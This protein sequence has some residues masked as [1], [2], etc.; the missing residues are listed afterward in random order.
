MSL[1][2]SSAMAEVSA[3]D[4]AGEGPGVMAPIV[5]Q[6]TSGGSVM[7]PGDAF[8]IGA[9]FSRAAGDLVLS[10]AADQPVVVVRDFFAMEEPPRLET[11]SGARIEGALA[12]RLAGSPSPGQYAA[13]D[14]AA[15][16]SSEPIGKI[17]EITGEAT[18]TRLDGTKLAL[19]KDMPIF[20]GDVI[21]TAEGAAAKVVFIDESTFAIGENG[22]IVLDELVFDPA[23]L[24]G[25]SSFSVLEGVFIFVSGGIAENNPD[26]MVVKT[27]VATMG[28]RGTAVA[29]QAAEESEQNLIILL[30]EQTEDGQE[31]TGAVKVTTDGGSVVLDEPNEATSLDSIFALPSDTFYALPEDIAFLIR[32]LQEAIPDSLRYLKSEFPGD[33]QAGKGGPEE[34]AAALGGI[35]PAAGETG[36]APDEVIQVTNAD[37][38]ATSPFGVVPP[39][40]LSLIGFE[41]GGGGAG[42]SEHDDVLPLP[43]VPGAIVGE[44]EAPPPPPAPPA[45]DFILP[46]GLFKLAQ[47]VDPNDILVGTLHTSGP[48]GASFTF[49][50]AGTYLVAW[51]AMDEGDF[52]I[53]S[54]LLLDSVFLNDTLLDGFNG[55]TFSFAG[56][57]IPA[58]ADVTFAGV[59][60]GVAPVE[61]AGQLKFDNNNLSAAQIEALLGLPP[62]SLT[63]LAN[64]GNP[65]TVDVAT[66]GSVLLL[67]LTVQAGDVL[68][69]GYNF[70][71]TDINGG[72][73]GNF[74]DFAFFFVDA[75]AAEGSNIA[76][77]GDDVLVGG[78]G[79]DVI[80]ALAGNDTVFGSSGADSLIG[81]AGDDTLFGGADADALLGGPGGDVLNG[82]AG[83]D[84][85][86][87]GD[88]AD[89][90]IGGTGLNT[91]TG[92]A[93]GDAFFFQSLAEGVPVATD[94]AFS[95]QASQI[96][97]FQS[98]TDRFV[99]LNTGFGF[100]AGTTGTLAELES[101]SGNSL[102]S[103][104]ANYDG[105]GAPTGAD[106]PH[107]IFDPASHTLYYDSDVNLPGY[108]VIAEL[109]DGAAVGAADIEISNQS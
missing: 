90:L 22:R 11:E 65:N 83:N 40:V 78:P 6:A 4:R 81:N 47:S 82:G 72:P 51:G 30:A 41:P 12:V 85:L 24:E 56:F 36:G 63:A 13:A 32:R 34:T 96:T 88:D 17:A 107:F 54:P 61:G 67:E 2:S 84:V 23:T 20:Q 105:S 102:F 108:T 44:E 87:G 73:G 50:E 95:G 27:P 45:P 100:D 79:N 98:G 42:G 3:P 37:P 33:G 92:G 43:P 28:I 94:Q 8:L 46:G 5:L 106:N 89:L 52:I 104:I 74:N 19:A 99:F 10:G 31:T 64:D 53:D 97:D 68:S 15:G 39:P 101:E 9:A 25:N 29:V 93:G 60:S 35:A 57:T 66:H 103:I 58:N 59:V 86:S 55:A 49:S 16:G 91:L 109:Q 71:D 75:D 48:L 38:L 1:D 26:Q 21:E 77:P 76:T 62:G 69:F 14:D 7:V 70:I 80:D 18:A